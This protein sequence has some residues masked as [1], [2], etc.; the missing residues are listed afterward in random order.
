MPLQ[1]SSGTGAVPNIRPGPD[2]LADSR[3]RLSGRKPL[4]AVEEPPS[5]APVIG[6]CSWE[7]RSYRLVPCPDRA[8]ARAPSLLTQSLLTDVHEAVRLPWRC[9]MT[10]LRRRMDEDMLARGFAERT[11]ETYLWAVA[12]LARFY[13]RSP[14]RI[15]DAE[16]QAYLVHL[17]RDRQ[18]SWS[19]C[20]IVVS[21]CGSSSTRR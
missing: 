13:R 12:G 14:D 7:I 15:S 21:G 9:V 11:R 2:R 16:V 1:P 8:I 4:N 17:L 20:N 19:T 3:S 6:R 18:R 10:E 5:L